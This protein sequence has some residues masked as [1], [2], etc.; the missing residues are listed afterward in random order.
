VSDLADWI[1]PARTALVIVDMQ[2]DFASPEGVLG[3]AGVDMSVV[4]PALAAARRLAD[5]ARAAGAPVV[6]VGL[7]T[8]TAFDSQAWRL[9]MARRGGDPDAEIALCRAGERGADFYGPMPR[10]GEL[11]VPKTRYS[12]FFGTPL[13]AA[14]KA[15]GVDTLVVC[16]V[17]TDCCVDCTVRDAFHLDYHIFIAADACASYDRDLHEGTLKSLE[18]NF[19][20]LAETDAIA[21]AWREGNAHG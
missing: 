10:P 12:G 9:R 18:L 13:D 14:L 1:A 2:V 15:K 8:Q 4:E 11:V 21:A 16:G 7:Q 20:I 6:F 5:A 3:K 19:A 17:T